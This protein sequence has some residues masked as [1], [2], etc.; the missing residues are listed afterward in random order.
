MKK[1]IFKN[2]TMN[3]S[4]LQRIYHYPIYS[5]DSKIYSDKGFVYINDGAQGGSH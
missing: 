2:N 3:E 4:E 1:N 5:R